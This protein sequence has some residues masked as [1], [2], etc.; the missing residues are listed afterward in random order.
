MTHPQ[1]NDGA[2]TLPSGPGHLHTTFGGRFPYMKN[3]R[4]A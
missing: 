1:G 2:Y 4:S 3:D